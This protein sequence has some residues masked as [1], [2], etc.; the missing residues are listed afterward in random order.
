VKGNGPCDGGLDRLLKTGDRWLGVCV[1]GGM[2]LA[3]MASGQRPSADAK[4]HFLVQGESHWKFSRRKK[5][6]S[7]SGPMV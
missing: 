7:F 2:P 1:R 3:P 4:K 5:G 6:F